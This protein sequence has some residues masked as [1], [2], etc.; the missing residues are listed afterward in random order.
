MTKANLYE[1]DTKNDLTRL[2]R[3]ER[4]ITELKADE[5]AVARDVVYEYRVRYLYEWKSEQ[6][7]RTE[8]HEHRQAFL[9]QLFAVATAAEKYVDSDMDVDAG[10]KLQALIAERDKA[11]EMAAPHAAH[12]GK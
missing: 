12:W 9:E 11:N 7:A 2:I 6:Y 10:P 5:P 4:Q 8:F 3:F 1:F